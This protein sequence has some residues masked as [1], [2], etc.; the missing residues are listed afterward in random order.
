M[1]STDRD[2]FKSVLGK[3]SQ[4]FTKEVTPELVTTYW[5]ALKD[6]PI[7]TIQRTSDLHLKHG[8]FFPKPKELRPKGEDTPVVVTDASFEYSQRRAHMNL[9][10]MRAR[11]P[12]KFLA[13]VRARL[14]A[15]ILATAH[16]SMPEYAEA[17]RTDPQLR[18]AAGW[19]NSMP[20][21]P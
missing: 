1:Y 8:K 7:G 15:R 6:L 14:N 21:E 16:P 19:L 18:R 10:E 12:D 3:L 13:E 2:A 5:E 4:V 17:Y 9:E 11:D 20:R